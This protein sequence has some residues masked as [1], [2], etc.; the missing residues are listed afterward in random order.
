M[1]HQTD[2]L[3]AFGEEIRLRI[4]RLVSAQE[5]SVTEV[6]DILQIPQPRVSRHLA[7]L[8][9]SDLVRDRRDGNRVYYRMDASPPHPFAGAVWEAVCS[10]WSGGEFFPE[11]RRRETAR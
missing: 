2:T 4:L 9:R 7:V 10:D 3:R 6:V 5:L 8:R 1:S 11:D